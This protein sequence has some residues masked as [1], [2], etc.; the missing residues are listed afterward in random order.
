MKMKSEKMK[1]F[2][3]KLKSLQEIVMETQCQEELS[4]TNLQY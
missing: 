1:N 3:L 2:A 4:I